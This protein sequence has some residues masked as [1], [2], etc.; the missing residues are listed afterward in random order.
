MTKTADR[1][2]TRNKERLE[3]NFDFADL[4]PDAFEASP[5]PGG[6]GTIKGICVMSAGVLFDRFLEFDGKTL[7]AVVTLG[8]KPKKGVQSFRGHA[9]ELGAHLGWV[10]NF[11]RDGEKVRADLK[12]S[13]M[14][15]ASPDGDFGAY[16]MAMAKEE[17][18]AIGASIVIYSARY[19][20]RLEKDGTT[21]KDD[22]GRMLPPVLRP[23]SLESVDI[24][25]R[26]A[27]TPGGLFAAQEPQRPEPDEN[28]PGSAPAEQETTMTQ[29]AA[30]AETPAPVAPAAAPDAAA[31]RAQALADER[32]RTAAIFAAAL[33]GQEEI[34]RKAVSDGISVEAAMGLFLQDARARGAQA[35]QALNKDPAPG[36]PGTTPPPAP[37][38]STKP[39]EQAAGAGSPLGPDGKFSADAAKAAWAKRTAAEENEFKTEEAFCAYWKNAAVRNPNGE[40]RFYRRREGY[41]RIQGSDE[42]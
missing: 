14:A 25:G 16:V 37:G 15:A 18:H 12:I 20:W 5:E 24:V 8:N 26:G 31:I 9:W 33:P 32:K 38:A 7:D 27:A 10:T 35:L 19:E 11:R 4:A 2:P 6:G 42:N 13:K 22:K 3:F 41:T 1:R 34:A 17:P 39:S 21:K 36:L 23:E 29:A 28:Q 40:P 30:Q